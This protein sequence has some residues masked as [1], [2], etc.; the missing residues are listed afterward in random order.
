MKS[1][2]G[3]GLGS[4]RL[5]LIGTVKCSR[6]SEIDLLEIICAWS[7]ATSAILCRRRA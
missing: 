6:P 3:R 7:L 1:R 5:L 2:P 4:K